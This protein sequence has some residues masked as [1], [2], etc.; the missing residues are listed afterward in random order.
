[1]IARSWSFSHGA[2]A[3]PSGSNASTAKPS[4]QAGRPSM[5]NSHCH[6]RSPRTPSDSRIRLEI[7]AP[8][9]LA[10]GTAIMNRPTKRASRACGNQVVR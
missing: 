3:G 4:T 1:M 9:A 6:P 7:G 2:L 8:I 10:S 5:M